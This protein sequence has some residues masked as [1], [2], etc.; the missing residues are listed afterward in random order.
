MLAFFHPEQLLHVPKTYLSRG[1]MR[2][3]QEIPERASRLLQAIKAL[4]FDIRTPRDYGLEPLQAV[5]T[6]AYL[7]FLKTAHG[8]WLETSPDWGDEV[9]SNIYVR[10]PN[11]MQGI[12][13]EAAYYLADGSCP[14]GE[15]TWRSAYWSAQSAA[16]GAHAVVDGER[17]AYALCRPPGHHTRKD[18]AGGFCYVNNA[19]V[20]AQILRS[21]YRKVAV[22]DTD[23]HHGQG[24]QDIFY[25]RSDVLTVSVHANPTNFY[26]V[27][28]GFEDEQGAGEGLGYSRN[29]AVPHGSSEEVYFDYVDRA[30]DVVRTFQPDAL[31][32]AHGFDIYIEDPQ[33][34]LR[35][36]AEGFAR[37]GERIASLGLPTVITQEGGYHLP[38]L[39]SN[40]HQFFSGFLGHRA[41]DGIH[42]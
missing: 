12:L 17:Q 9:M 11:A 13:A 1:A 2:E 32:F 14:I 34:P 20:A 8:K 38:T 22:L 24:T 4:N 29:F 27:V 37:L 25:D 36:S 26:P 19:A 39:D 18:S 3:P 35:V 16:A 28:A 31:V 10:E 33:S 6:K 40:A 30:L 5:H 21:R 42:P 41:D 15:A 7:D 23:V